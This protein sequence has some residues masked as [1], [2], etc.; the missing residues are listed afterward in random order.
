M[1][2]AVAERHELWHR[3]VSE[4]EASGQPIRAFCRERGLKESGACQA[5]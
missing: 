5:L 4:Q 2:Q 3:R 1:K